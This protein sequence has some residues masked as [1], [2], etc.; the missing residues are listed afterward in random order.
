ME[1]PKHKPERVWQTI[2][3]HAQPSHHTAPVEV[4]ARALDGDTAPNCASDRA[5]N[6]RIG[7]VFSDRAEVA[8]GG[9]IPH[10]TSVDI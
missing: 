2:P 7:R 1:R 6:K 8:N 4:F 3:T 9:L 5:G 10:G